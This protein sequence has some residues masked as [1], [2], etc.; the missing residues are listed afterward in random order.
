MRTRGLSLAARVAALDEAVDAGSGRI[1]A[2]DLAPARRVV[3]RA[4]ERLSLSPDHTV[5]ALAGSTGSGKSSLLNALAGSEIAETGVRRPTTEHPAAAIWGT[6]AAAGLLDWLGVDDRRHLDA[7]AAVSA[8]LV[9]ID[10]PDHDSVVVEH[11]LRAER[12]LERVDLFVWVADP[13]KYADAALHERYLRPLAKQA[14][15]VVLAL[16]QVD[17]LTPVERDACLADLRRLANQDG[18]GSVRVL[19]V[20]AATGEGIDAL[21]AVLRE[22]ARRRV[23]VTARLTADVRAEATRLAHAC[24]EGVPPRVRRAAREELVT[25]LEEVAGVG[26]VV[27][28]VRGSAARRARAGTG[29]PPTRWLV[30]FRSDPLRRLH[31]DRPAER[32]EL[33]RTSLRVLGAAARARAGN[34]VRAYTDTATAGAPDAWVLAA[35]ARARVSAAVLAGALDQAVAGTRLDAERRPTWWR[36]VGVVQWILFATLLAGL[37]WLAALALLGYFGLPDPSTAAWFGLPAPTVLAAGGAGVGMMLAVGARFAGSLGARRRATWARAR[38]RTAVG[39]VTDELLVGPLSE[40][41]R[42]LERCRAAAR[43]AAV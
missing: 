12:L 2:L 39:Q 41:M 28:A 20:S 8:G 31:L 34:A 15:V 24:G 33:A 18:L 6:D 11:R 29:W 22:V 16:N 10:L 3:V 13:Q 37:L 23:A 4:R 30:R 14:D 43:L 36:A 26:I 25:A 21:R 38:L 40:E 35:R 19:P 27:D 5:V 9:L 32:P 42:A 1:P 17:R 7:H